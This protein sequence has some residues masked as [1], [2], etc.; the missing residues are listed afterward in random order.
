MSGKKSKPM[1]ALPAG[2]GVDDEDVLRW[3]VPIVG[4]LSRYERIVGLSSDG[5]TCL[6]RAFLIPGG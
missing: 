5:D 6:V 2:K 4:F 3:F 1:A